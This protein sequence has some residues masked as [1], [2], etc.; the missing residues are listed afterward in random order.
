MSC[1]IPT[2][3]I[4]ICGFIKQGNTIK[5]I[6]L[7]FIDGYS[8]DLTTAT[9]RMSI[10]D[11]NKK[12]IDISN[13]NGITV[14]DSTTLEVDQILENDFP[15]GVF[16]GDIKIIEDDGVSTTYFNIEYTIIKKY[17]T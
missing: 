13:G 6:T 12:I 17:T 14:V 3:K 8:G 5:K 9:I 15:Y 4:P 16:L 1:D 10:F 7:N 11:K 2:L